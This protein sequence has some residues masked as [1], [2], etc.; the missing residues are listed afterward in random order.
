MDMSHQ[1]SFARG[2]V[3]AKIIVCIDVPRVKLEISKLRTAY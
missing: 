3:D 2:R 1:K